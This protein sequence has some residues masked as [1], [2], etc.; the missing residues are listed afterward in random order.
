LVEIPVTQPGVKNTSAS[1][2]GV[3]LLNGIAALTRSFRFHRPRG[4]FCHDGWCQQCKVRLADGRNVLACR[5]TAA[6]FALLQRPSRL[7]RVLGVLA[8]M[9]W[10]WFHE[11]RMLYPKVLRQFYLRI[12]RHLSGA[13][14]ISHVGQESVSKEIRDLTFDTLVVGGGE[15]GARA[16][17]ACADAGR[18]VLLIDSQALPSARKSQLGSKGISVFESTTCVGLYENATVA[19]C[20]SQDGPVSVRFRELVVATGAYDALPSFLGNDLPGIVGGRGLE[21]LLA[22][23][24]LPNDIKIGVVATG[25]SLRQIYRSL[26][27][28]DRRAAW[29]ATPDKSA[30]LGCEVYTNVKIK[31]AQG[32]NRI[33]SVSFDSG[34]RLS[35]DLLVIGL[36]QP[37]YELQLQAGKTI[38]IAGPAGPLF[39]EGQG[40]VP[41]LVVGDA[42]GISM[43]EP[44]RVENATAAFLAKAPMPIN[45]PASPDL[46]WGSDR[47]ILCPCED[48]RVGDVRKAISDGFDN[49]ESLKRRTG[50]GTGPCQGK[51]CHRELARCLVEQGIE[52]RLPTIRPLLRP[53]PLYSFLAH[54]SE[55]SKV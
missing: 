4:A 36:S 33:R 15:A 24:A 50:A 10:P 41:T 43:D 23:E 9:H 55:T 29:L 39:A 28:A 5:A 17:G 1:L 40:M 34:A 35:C 3:A 46:S 12:L 54:R 6:D 18:T 13:L 11:R 32:R 44:D 19:F 38:A 49:V 20:T 47:A 45:V 53:T 37:S 52:V 27:Q 22:T 2:A 25:A 8:E 48:V 26:S 30:D 31:R 16:A 51:L 42:S 21:K 7:R 14:P